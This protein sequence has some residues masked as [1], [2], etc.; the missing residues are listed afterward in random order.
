MGGKN[1]YMADIKKGGQENI[2]P[3]AAG[4]FYAL[5]SMGYENTAAIADLIDNSID[6]KASNI[7]VSVDEDLNKIFIADDGTGMS[8][9]TLRTAVQL[10]G[11]K[12]H[13]SG[14]DLGKYGLGLITASLSMG[15]AIR[16]VTKKDNVYNT[17]LLDYDTV[18]KEDSFIVNFYESTDSEIASFDYRTRGADSGTVLIID[19][20]DKL[21]YTSA[22]DLINAIEESVGEIFRV[23]LS[24]GKHIYINDSEVA[25]YD[26]LLLAVKGNRRLV[27]MDINIESNS[28]VSGKMH[29]LAVLIPDQG[30]KANRSL[31]LN[32]K[33]QG[34]YI[35]R[36]KREIASALEFSDIFKKHNDFN[37]LRIELSFNP[38]L[39][40]LMGINLK[41]HDVAPSQEVIN[42]LKTILDE[43][44]KKVRDEMKLKQRKKDN[45][46]PFIKPINGG[47]TN[48]NVPAL[49]GSNNKNG[50]SFSPVE[51]TSTPNNKKYEFA[52]S[53]YA[54]SEND[55]LFKLSTLNEKI[56]VRYNICN[57]YYSDSILADDYGI[58]I[59]EALDNIIEASI[60]AYLGVSGSSSLNA[61]AEAMADNFNKTE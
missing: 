8:K 32:I 57:K 19:K 18:Q 35:L 10:G 2:L 27:D 21:Q 20:C 47:A 58:K 61:F 37:L 26:P 44:I 28:G 59:K 51:P 52:F 1:Y 60:R 40:D 9:D 15:R 31:R 39:D 38:D 6:A 54:G 53:T 25:F 50:T 17:V 4:L 14:T 24:E 48:I 42:A 7:W 30:V 5:R 56:T 43:P 23:Y 45:K 29:V 34:F 36:N 13:D 55:P 33:G 11:K 3:D 49:V 12:A 22:K 41:K 46:N 16:I